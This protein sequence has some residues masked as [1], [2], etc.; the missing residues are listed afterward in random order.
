MDD[1]IIHEAIS[2]L[3]QLASELQRTP[4]RKE[5]RERFSRAYRAIE[6]VGGYSILVRMAGLDPIKES[7]K[8]PT[9]EIFRRS[10]VDQLSTF[11]PSPRQ[12]K[13]AHEKTIFIPDTHFPFHS[14]QSF[15][16]LYEFIDKHKP[17]RVIQ[18]GDL[19]DMFAFSKFSKSMLLFN[20]KEEME[21]GRSEAVA[22]WEKI[23]SI[24]P[25]AEKIQIVGNHDIR[26]I[27]SVLDSFPALE[28][29]VEKHVVELMTFDGVKTIPSAREEYFF[30]DVQV[31][32]GHFSGMGKHRDYAQMNTVI[33]HQHVGHVTYRNLKGK[34]IWELG[35]GLLGD[36]ESKAFSYTP[37]RTL[38]WHLGFGWLDEYGPRFIAL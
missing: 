12:E 9:N 5:Y 36:P 14:R 24:V 35:C 18:L 26:P 16:R 23:K 8:K 6:R 30:D 20:P 7:S 1:Q 13:I 25:D 11:S 33:G 28:H 27:K 10:I 4:T 38:N 31:I 29:V 22:M 37:Q 34:I 32:H 3:K 19:Y 2:N 21:L 15:D 17:K